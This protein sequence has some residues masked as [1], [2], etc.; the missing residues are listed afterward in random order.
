MLILLPLSANCYMQYTNLIWR[1]GEPYS[2]KFDDIYY[3]STRGESISGE[4][5]FNHVFFRNNGLPERW[6]ENRDFVIAELGFGSALNCLLTIRKWLNYLDEITCSSDAEGGVEDKRT[7]HYIAIEKYP[8]SAEDIALLHASHAELK[9]YC[10]EMVGN[11]PPAIKASHSRRL[12]NGRV[13]IHYKFMDA[14]DALNNASLNVDAWY[15]DGFSPANN[16]GI[17]SDKLFSKLP[18]NSRLNATCATYTSAGLV[19]RNLQDAGFEVKKVKGH[20]KKRDMI[21]A[22]LKFKPQL[23]LRYADK[24]W[25]AQREND[26]EYPEKVTILGGGIAGLSIA[27]SMVQRG[28]SVTIIDTH[29]SEVKETSSNLAAIIYPRLSLDNDVD[30]EFYMSAFCHALSVINKLQE[31]N[32]K[33]FWFDGGLL[34]SIDE[35]RINLILTKFSFNSDYISINNDSLPQNIKN[36][37]QIF[38]EYKKAGTVIPEKLC[39][40][41]KRE[42]GDML[43]FISSDITKV[44]YDGDVWSCMAGDKVINKEKLLIIANGAKTKELECSAVFPVETVR[45]QMM[46]LNVTSASQDISKVVNSDV[47]VTPVMSEK[48][49]V[50]GTYSRENKSGEVED[51]DNQALFE[52]VNSLYPGVFEA[53]SYKRAWVGFRAMSKDRVPIVGAVPDLEFFNNEYAD[54]KNGDIKRRYQPAKNLKGLY[55]SVAHGSRGFTSCFLSAEIIASQLLG[56]PSFVSKKVL[57]YLNPSRF[58]VNDLKRR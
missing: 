35:K 20:G 7:L 53:E 22:Q 33:K 49:V 29:G 45:G 25:F 31:K 54:I 34:Q 48:H 5:E 38:V 12:F 51:R 36:N 18:E 11:Y 10:D 26:S 44:Q 14:Y 43:R 47:Y 13:V 50:G 40:A 56:E 42:C 19:K 1:D 30:T 46:E 3:S 39:E 21:V 6:Q 58:I 37:N 28:I 23:D 55:V 52:S 16:P 4:S 2:D 27:Y 17:W 24:P 9:P 32:Q 8:F 57:D 41:L 15:L